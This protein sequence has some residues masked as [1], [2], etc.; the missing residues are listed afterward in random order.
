MGCAHYLLF[1][2]K[3]IQI[4]YIVIFFIHKLCFGLYS[5]AQLHITNGKR[6]AACR[7]LGLHKTAV[8]A[9]AFVLFCSA[10]FL[11]LR[12]TACAV[13]LSQQQKRRLPK[14]V[15]RNYDFNIVDNIIKM[16]YR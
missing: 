10:T 7:R 1:G 5:T 12:G 2:I 11:L 15:M 16:L 9:S 6:F 8:G 14:Y 4:K 13:P 3:N